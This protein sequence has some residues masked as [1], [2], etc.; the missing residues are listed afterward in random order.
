MSSS[1][2][3]RFVITIAILIICVVVAFFVFK[4]KNT[5]P[6]P[7]HVLI[8][9][10][11]QPT[12]GSLKAPLHIVAFEDLKCGNCRRYNMSVYPK[13]KANYI[14]TKRA[15]YTVIPLSFLPS[16]TPAGNA[17]L[18]L[19]HQ[20]PAFFFDFVSYVYIH[21]PPESTNWATLSALLQMANQAT[22]K[23][24]INALSECMM[25]NQYV[26]QLT[27]NLKLAKTVM[28]NGV[29]T[30]SVYVNGVLVRP[31]TFKRFNDLANHT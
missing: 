12:T 15:R 7:A 18:C 24:D 20:K 5:A 30:P 3:K 1:S 22:P 13:I 10:I 23:A 21:Q 14:N 17:A 31:L 11:G 19:Y 27:D 16:S 9:T 6:P 4:P 8:S 26:S 28:H 2:G 25:N 29:E